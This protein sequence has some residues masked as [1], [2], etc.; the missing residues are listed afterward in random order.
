MQTVAFGEAVSPMPRRGTAGFQERTDQR[1]QRTAYFNRRAEMYGNLR[2]L[3][4]PALGQGFAIPAD[5]TDLRGQLAPI[6]LTY[7]DEGRL[8]LLPKHRREPAVGGAGAKSLTELIGHSPDEADALVLAIHG[9][10]GK[11][12]R[13]A[14]TGF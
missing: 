8:K 4:D 9:M 2:E 7:D 5:Y 13:P 10:R 1:E 14:V 6:P 3:L 11:A 12:V